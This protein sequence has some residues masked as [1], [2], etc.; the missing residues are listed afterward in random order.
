MR[1]AEPGGFVGFPFRGHAVAEGVQRFSLSERLHWEK[2]FNT[3]VTEDTECT[4][5]T[6][7][8]VAE[9]AVEDGMVGVDAAIAQKG[10]ITAGFFALCGV[11]FDDE[12][13]FFVVRSFGNDLAEGI[14][15]ERVAPEFQASIA[16]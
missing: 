9:P 3:E 11:S 15:D 1:P 2:E 4:E 16:V 5:K 8:F 12:D 6:V 14:G 10:P 13:F 7:L